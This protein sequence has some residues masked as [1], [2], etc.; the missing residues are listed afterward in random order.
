MRE[1][2]PFL[3]VELTQDEFDAGEGADFPIKYIHTR[4]GKIMKRTESTHNR[5]FQYFVDKIPMPASAKPA[6]G[7][8]KVLPALTETIDWL[9]A[10]KVPIA[11]FMQIEDFFKKVMYEMDGQKLTTHGA[12]EA[13]AHIVW[14]PATP[15]QYHIRIPTQKVSAASVK[16]EWDHLEEGDEIIVDI[17]SHNSMGA[18]FS[19]TD[20]NDDKCSTCY[21]GVIGKLNTKSPEYKFRFNDT[22]KKKIEIG[23]WDI[24]GMERAEAPSE[25][26]S[27][28]SRITYANNYLGNANRG[29]KNV[30]QAPFGN[31]LGKGNAG[32]GLTKNGN[33]N[34]LPAN[35][36]MF[37]DE[38]YDFENMSFGEAF[39]DMFGITQQEY[40]EALDD[41]DTDDITVMGED[42]SIIIHDIDVSDDTDFG[43]QEYNEFIHLL[44]KLGD[45]EIVES[46]SNGIVTLED[47]FVVIPRFEK[48]ISTQNPSGN[49]WIDRYE[50]EAGEGGTERYLSDLEKDALEKEEGEYLLYCELVDLYVKSDMITEGN[51]PTYLLYIYL[52]TYLD[53]DGILLT[54]EDNDI[55]IPGGPVSDQKRKAVMEFLE[56]G[57]STMDKAILI[58][59]L[60]EK[61]RNAKTAT[62]ESE[63]ASV[64]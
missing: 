26:L 21:S 54:E 34:Q 22:D 8:K 1:I 52:L 32:S 44:S 51:S 60:L 48:H 56:H 39:L 57:T 19:G 42:D 40:N 49:V 46:I 23:L 18:F 14:N 61:S 28:V 59:F 47:A 6:T 35:R 4:A 64:H 63:N 53:D 29:G 10:G 31:R 9:P 38:D 33:N 50:E 45:D 24:F 25:W 2:T 43:I 58:A 12:L 15:D 5:F 13:M 16:Y 20:N 3:S 27:K 55:I 41:G 36:D 62:G 17:H 11:L 30:Y 7:T 37:E